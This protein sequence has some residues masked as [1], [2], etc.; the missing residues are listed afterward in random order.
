MGIWEW[1]KWSQ[2]PYQIHKIEL[3]MHMYFAVDSLL[4]YLHS[5]L[6]IKLFFS[7]FAQDFEGEICTWT[8]ILH[9]FDCL[10]QRKTEKNLGGKNRIISRDWQAEYYKTNPLKKFC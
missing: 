10:G 7:L 3:M 9:N 8:I 5:S 1:E 4:Y 6:S 2:M